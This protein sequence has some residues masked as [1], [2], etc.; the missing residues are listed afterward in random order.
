[1]IRD[2]PAAPVAMMSWPV[3]KSSTMEEEMEDWGR[4][5]GRIKLMGEA[6]KPNELV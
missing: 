2:P 4:F 6:A 1:M 5:P 3:S